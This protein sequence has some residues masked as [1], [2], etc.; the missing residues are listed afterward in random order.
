MIRRPRRFMDYL[1]AVP[2]VGYM[3]GCAEIKND[4]ERPA[5]VLWAMN[6][7]LDRRSGVTAFENI[8][9]PGNQTRLF[10]PT[11]HQPRRRSTLQTGSNFR[12]AANHVGIVST[13]AWIAGRAHFCRTRQFSRHRP[14]IDSGIPRPESSAGRRLRGERNREPVQRRQ[15]GGHRN[16]FELF[17]SRYLNS[18]HALLASRAT[19]T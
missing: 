6:P 16:S 18:K 7:C 11:N 9:T 14:D 2:L 8:G 13:F 3:L 10:R 5:V 15:S 12:S 1:E 19:C 4:V 17:F